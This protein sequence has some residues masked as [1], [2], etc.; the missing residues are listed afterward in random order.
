MT[1]TWYLVPG[2]SYLVPD[3]WYLVP[4]TYFFLHQPR[5]LRVEH[6]R[7]AAADADLFVNVVQVNLDGAF[8]DGQ[9]LCDRPIAEALRDHLDDLNL[10]GG[11]HLR[12]FP[13][14]GL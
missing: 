2:T 7:Q 9:P 3:V 11:E 1:G 8:R 13:G 12:G 10:A 14:G 6:Q 5:S 4:G